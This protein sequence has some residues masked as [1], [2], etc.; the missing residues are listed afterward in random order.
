MK[1]ERSKEWWMRRVDK[2]VGAPSAG[3]RACDWCNGS[4]LL[5]REG[6]AGKVTETP[7]PACAAPAG[8]TPGKGERTP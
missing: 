7:C 6:Q 1:L 2:E 8:L 5:I 3:P 4:R